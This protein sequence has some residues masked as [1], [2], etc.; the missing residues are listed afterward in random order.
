MLI[1]ID[2]IGSFVSDGRAGF[3]SDPKTQFAVIRAYEVLGEI[4]KRLPAEFREANPQINWRRLIG[5]R[6]FLA[7][8]YEEVILEFVWNAVEDL[9]NLR[10]AVIKLI[11]TP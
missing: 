5:F 4:A 10:T 1:H 11:E 3:M 9:P 8:N 7:H 2:M 6:D